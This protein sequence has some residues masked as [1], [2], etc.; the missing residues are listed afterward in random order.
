MARKRRSVVKTV[1]FDD[2]G[3]PAAAREK[4]VGSLAVILFLTI[5]KLLDLGM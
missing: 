2:E 1:T 4:K 5:I 3:V